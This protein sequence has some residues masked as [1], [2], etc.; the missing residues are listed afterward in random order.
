MDKNRVAIVTEAGN[1]L[2]KAMADLLIH[3]DYI[4]IIAAA[5]ESYNKLSEERSNVRE[6]ELVQIDLS[7]DNSLAHLKDLVKRK[8]GKLDVLINNAETVNGFGHKI[9]QLNI[10]DVKYLFEI[11]FFS[12]L[13]IIQLMKPLL[14]MSAQPKIINVT[15]ALGDL[16]KMNDENFCY[17]NYTLTGYS[18]AKAA[19]N[20]YTHLQCKEFKPDKI[21][22]YSFDPVSLKNCTY[23][24]V[25]ICDEI[26]E[27]FISLIR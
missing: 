19:L 4:V 17:S 20:M 23:N 13:K 11:N 12:V 3:Q 6:F 22:I 14:E 7:S 2:G 21:N 1:G 10:N 8:Y 16:S 26:K 18:C 15:S 24:S 9:D 27:Q 25:I 5:G